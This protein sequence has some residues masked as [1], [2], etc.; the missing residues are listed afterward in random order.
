MKATQYEEILEAKKKIE[1]QERQF[2]ARCNHVGK[3]GKLKIVSIGGDNVK[4]L[5]CGTEFSMKTVIQEDQQK[6]IR[7]I[8]DMLNQIR[9]F[10]SD[11]ED[12]SKL[13]NYL[14]MITFE[15]SQLPRNYEKVIDGMLRGKNKKKDNKGPRESY[16]HYGAPTYG[17]DRKRRS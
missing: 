3:H 6:A 9:L 15:I 16:G 2:K 5:N 17:F 1:D 11:K 12:D 13:L 8:I 14:G 4:C 7:T 10:S